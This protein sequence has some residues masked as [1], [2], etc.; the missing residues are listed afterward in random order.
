[1]KKEL[2]K[3]KLQIRDNHNEYKQLKKVEAQIAHSIAFWGK[4]M[5]AP[6]GNQKAIKE[7]ASAE[8]GQRLS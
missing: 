4:P 1:M 8:G 5:V 6:R 3:I 7:E 2:D